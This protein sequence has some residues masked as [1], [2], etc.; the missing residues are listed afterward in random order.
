VPALFAIGFRDSCSRA[1]KATALQGLIVVIAVAQLAFP[2]MGAYHSTRD[3][4]R[5]VLQLR[6][7]GEAIATYRFFHHS[8]FYYTGYLITDELNDLQSLQQFA[9]TH[10]SALIVTKPDG[11][12]EISESKS[13]SITLL[14]NQGNFRLLRLSQ[15]QF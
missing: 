7:T 12:M 13:F 3:I 14:G 6:R 2:V 4:A 8:L 10:A 1:F 5:Q 11:L 15:K 9:Q